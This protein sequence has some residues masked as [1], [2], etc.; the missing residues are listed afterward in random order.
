M[1][2]FNYHRPNSVA[3]AAKL[4]GSAS[5]GK[6]LAGGQTL[7]PTIKQR[8]NKPSDLIDL[9]GIKDLNYVKVEGGKVVI[10]AL[11][12]HADVASSAARF[13]A[14]HRR[15][16]PRGPRAELRRGRIGT[17]GHRRHDDPVGA[18]SV[19]RGAE[20]CG[21]SESPAGR[22]PLPAR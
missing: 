6:L 20:S 22:H 13:F 7:L 19:D 1:Y 3:D 5:E 16:D 2:N 12:R 15:R 17:G 11:T 4:L 21:R 18:R 10:G 14:L 9:G 8:L